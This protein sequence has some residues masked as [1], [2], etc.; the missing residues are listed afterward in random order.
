MPVLLPP[1]VLSVIAPSPNAL[2]A[3]PVV[4]S[5]IAKWPNAPL[6]L[7]EVLAL[8]A[9]N[10]TAVF[11]YPAPLAASAESPIAVLRPIWLLT[12]PLPLITVSL[13]SARYPKAVLERDDVAYCIDWYP[14]AVLR[15]P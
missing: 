10:P 2:F 9:P 8:R 7:P 12:V 6:N 13:R 5:S 4:L 1:L 14:T 15:N 3:L 11:R